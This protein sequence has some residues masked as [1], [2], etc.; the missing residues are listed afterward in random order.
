V[1]VEGVVAG[2][3]IEPN[4]GLAEAVGLKVDDGIL[5]DERLR[6]S[7]PEIYAAGDVDRFYN[8][9]LDKYLRV[10]HEDNANT[11]GRAAGRAMAGASDPYHH[12]PFFYSD[13]SDLG[14]EAVG[15][16]DR[17][18]E[19]IADWQEELLPARGPAARCAALEPMGA[20]RRGAGPH[21]RAG[22]VSGR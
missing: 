6:T 21:P 1:A 15:E 16:L 13:L 7:A 12:L 8:S 3:G 18:L 20:G 9:D 14:Y 10:E 19:L 5:V 2:I 4:T 17:S 22:P 11:M